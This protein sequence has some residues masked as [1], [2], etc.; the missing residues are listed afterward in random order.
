MYGRAG[1]AE[2]FIQVLPRLYSKTKLKVERPDQPSRT[3]TR[4][5]SPQ[6]LE[7]EVGT[8]PAANEWVAGGVVTPHDDNQ[9]NL[10]ASAF[11]SLWPYLLGSGILS[12]EENPFT[13]DSAEEPMQQ[14]D[15]WQ[16]GSY[17]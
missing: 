15:E 3:V 16:Y 17:L 6:P 11:E 12:S 9:F 4:H 13:G 10:P 5:N 8:R 1:F 14:R 2:E 7:P